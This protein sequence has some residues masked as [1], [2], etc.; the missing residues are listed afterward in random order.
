MTRNTERYRSRLNNKHAITAAVSGDPIAMEAIIKNYA[1][2]INK[3]CL[4]TMYDEYG[5]PVQVVDDYMRLTL[6]SKLMYA[7]TKFAIR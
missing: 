3:L 1:H 4:R 2:Y 7:I 6:E 5:N